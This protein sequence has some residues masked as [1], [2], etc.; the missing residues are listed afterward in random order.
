MCVP[1][2]TQSLDVSGIGLLLPSIGTDLD[3]SATVLAWVMNA[4]ALAFGAMLLTFGTLADR[5]GPRRLL[6]AGVAGFGVASLLCGVATDS[7]VLIAARALQGLSSAACFTTSLSVVMAT[8]AEDRRPAAIGI[9]GAV[10]GAGSA[11]GPLV[12]GALT[13]AVGWR[14]FFFV[15]GP[16][17]LLALPAIAA[18]VG[19]RD[20]EPRTST[21]PFPAAGLAAVAVAFVGISLAASRAGGGSWLSV[22][23]LV[24]LAAAGGAVAFVV[25]RGRR[26]ARPVLDPAALGARWSRSAL[27]VA[28]TST[29]G[30]GVTLV[31]VSAYLQQ[32]RGL[33]ALEAGVTF[34]AFSGAFALAGTVNSLAVRRLGVSTTLVVAMLGCAA[35]FALLTTMAP[36]S[37]FPLVVAG[38]VVGGLGQG[39]AFAAST[40]ASL[41]GVPQAASGQATGA[42]QSTRLLGNVVGVAISTAVLVDLQGGDDTPAALARG[43]GAAMVLALGVSLVGAALVPLAVRRQTPSSGPTDGSGLAPGS[44]GP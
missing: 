30:F 28:F 39:L 31:V 9:W 14:A 34:L 16:I 13:T 40:T 3:A 4:N 18:L 7:T 43:D 19:S 6:L 23:T 10:S 26:G 15:N 29:W 42:T 21:A 24:P 20:R 41:S 12:A 38:L 22:A 11:L 36:A 35:G 25:A 5:F 8:F 17:C 27:A 37:A 33:S 32:V 44:I 2:L 1:L